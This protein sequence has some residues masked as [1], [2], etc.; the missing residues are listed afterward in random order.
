[1]R[2]CRILCSSRTKGC[3]HP[4]W[5]CPFPPP[6][7]TDEFFLQWILTQVPQAHTLE[8]LWILNK[9]SALNCTLKPVA[10]R[11]VPLEERPESHVLGGPLCQRSK[12]FSLLSLPWVFLLRGA[13]SASL[14]LCSCISPTPSNLGVCLLVALGDVHSASLFQSLGG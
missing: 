7:K 6:S 3:A 1:M 8:A 13:D 5:F 2:L 9:P 12:E 11:P 4:G 10:G 14:G